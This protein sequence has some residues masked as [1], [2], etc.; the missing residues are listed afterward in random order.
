M[1]VSSW[2]VDVCYPMA[3][4]LTLVQMSR[5][6][7]TA[8]AV[9]PHAERHAAMAIAEHVA[10]HQTHATA[11]T[12]GKPTKSHQSSRDAF[13]AHGLTILFV[14]FSGPP[15]E[16]PE[17]DEEAARNQGSNLFVTGIHPRLTESDVAR[18]FEKYGE[19]EKC[20][21]MR[22]PHTRESRG[23]GFVNMMNGQQADAAKEGLQGENIEGRTLSIEKARRSKPRTPTP[24]KYFGPPKRGMCTLRDTSAVAHNRTRTLSADTLLRLKRTSGQLHV[25]AAATETATMIVVAVMVVATNLMGEA[26]GALAMATAAMTVA[27]D[28]ATTTHLVSTATLRAATIA[29]VAVVVAILVADATTT[30]VIRA[31]VLQLTETHLLAARTTVAAMMTVAM[32]AMLVVDDS[33]V[34]LSYRGGS[35]RGLHEPSN[36]LAVLPTSTI[37][38]L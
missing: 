23:F 4:W 12:A 20:N 35:E 11:W 24:G 15:Q 34:A 17:E 33:A 28:V 27:T 8:S 3:S 7:T 19:V 9:D 1:K 2:I 10:L 29:T 21:I 16:P 13:E 36:V 26:T 32:T 18:M 31:V 22:D 38:G 14:K 30:I 5:G 25:A 6:R 37:A